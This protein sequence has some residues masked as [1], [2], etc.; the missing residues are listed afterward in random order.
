MLHPIDKTTR[1]HIVSKEVNPRYWELINEFRK[2]TGIPLILNTSFNDHGE[3][4][5]CSPQDA[6]K[7]FNGTG[8]DILVLEDFKLKKEG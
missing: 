8:L 1:P 5:V 2:V 7:D 4:I 6:I 3:P